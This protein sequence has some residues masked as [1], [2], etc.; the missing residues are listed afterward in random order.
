LSGLQLSKQAVLAL[1]PLSVVPGVS[2]T[3]GEA[4]R[5]QAQLALSP[6]RPL[7]MIS[8][9]GPLEAQPAFVVLFRP[10]PLGSGAQSGADSIGLATLQAPVVVFGLRE[11]IFESNPSCELFE[12]SCNPAETPTFESSFSN[13]GRLFLKEQLPIPCVCARTHLTRK[14][15]GK[16][17]RVCTRQMISFDRVLVRLALAVTLSSVGLT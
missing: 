3:C 5:L 1:E 14:A 17:V 8:S 12:T 7:G 13:D 6:E 16:R 4:F 10:Q 9:W 11:G 15:L 2:L